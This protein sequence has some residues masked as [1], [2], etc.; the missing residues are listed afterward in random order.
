MVRRARVDVRRMRDGHAVERN[1]D[2]GR[3]DQSIV[4]DI[5]CKGEHGTDERGCECIEAG[6]RLCIA[7]TRR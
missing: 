5:L 1:H 4:V 3:R 2:R 7:T 6:V